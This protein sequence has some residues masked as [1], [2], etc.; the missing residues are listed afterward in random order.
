[1]NDG[2][3]AVASP[4]VRDIGKLPKCQLNSAHFACGW[5]AMKAMASAVDWILS[6][7][8]SGISI[9]NSS[10]Y[11]ITT[12][13]VSSESSPSSLKLTLGDTFGHGAERSQDTGGRQRTAQSTRSLK[14]C[15]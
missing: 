1:V 13:T 11:A 14:A 12:S 5:L 6:A 3:L 8:L 15:M 9:P 4:E 2:K 10:S 7:S